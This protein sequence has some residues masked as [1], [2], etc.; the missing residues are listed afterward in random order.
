V[1]IELRR[2][3]GDEDLEVLASIVNATTPD[4]PTSLDLM[5][6]QDRTYPGGIRLFALVD[7][8]PVGVGTVGRIYMYPPEYDAVWVTLNVLLEARRRGVGTALL[9]ATGTVARDAG[10]GFL[11]VPVSE[12]RPDA[13]RFLEHR[14][15]EEFERQKVVRLDL[16][17]HVAP[18]LDVPD[19]TT[20][21]TLAERPDLVPGIHAVALETFADIPGGDR[22]MA[23]G[24][25]A[26]FRARDVDPLP[27]WGFII[28]TE[29]STGAVV[30]YAS[31]YA[32]PDGTT[33]GWHDMT[34]VAHA[35]RGRGLATALKAATIRAAME[36][37]WTALETGNDVDNAP[38][39]A[40]NARLGY[41]PL[42]DSMTMRGPAM[43]A[44]PETAISGA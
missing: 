2:A 15:F 29:A 8:R 28:A 4:E 16:V 34:A 18:P 23:V 26:E 24:D 3:D 44:A 25:L 7:R 43:P 12:A 32:R 42:P 41:R 38:M 17:D 6:W 13:V 20:L 14:G 9:Q 11:L 1:T 10:K 36:H 33:I 30:G 5:R 31:L 21:T 39:R 22:P 19:G 35:W 37:G 27:T 40:V